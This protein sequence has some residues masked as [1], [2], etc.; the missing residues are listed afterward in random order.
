M[1]LLNHHLLQRLKD[2]VEERVQ[3]SEKAEVVVVVVVGEIGVVVVVRGV[4]VTQKR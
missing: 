2:G 3:E 4:L 1:C